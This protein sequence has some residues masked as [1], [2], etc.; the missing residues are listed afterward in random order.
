[1]R[2]GFDARMLSHPGIGRYI[3]CLVSEMALI[4]P[5]HEF[6]LFGEPGR[7]K[8]LGH[9]RNLR[10]VKWTSP[11]YSLGEQVTAP[12]DGYDLDLVHIPHFNIPLKT[13]TPMVVTIHDLIYMFF[14]RSVSNPLARCY[15]SVMIGAALG[16]ARNV[17]AVSEHT[18]KDIVRGFGPEAGK[19]VSTI[20][21]AADSSMIRVA[22]GPAISMV[23]KKYGL[24]DNVILYV[25]SVR[26][27]KNVA[28]LIGVYLKLKQ[29]G[30]PHQLVIAG[31]WDKKEDAIKTV[32]KDLDVKYL[33][34]VAP[35]DLPALYS[36]SDVLVN[37]SLYEGFGLTL[38]EAMQCGL[39]V[40]TSNVSSIPEVVGNAAY[41]LPPGSVDII[42]GTVYNVLAN[43]GLREGMV[44]EGYKQA[45]KFSWEKAARETLEV[46]KSAVRG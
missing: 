16:K 18:K 43:R 1:M 29:W 14:P 28:G 46:Y 6:I 44:A 13:R 31:R 37:L 33:G 24:A 11:I 36:M 2:I 5:E 22:D 39:A 21:E 38:L 27:H 3:K 30:V 17:I 45:S 40:V 35:E 34:E 41:T 19:K 12:F 4:A 26:P 20:Y 42:A 8:L 25:G 23:R 15:A 10:A 32:I 7:I 9:G